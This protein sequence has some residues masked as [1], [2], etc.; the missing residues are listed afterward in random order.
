M[1]VSTFGASQADSLDSCI[2]ATKK[3][4]VKFDR[5]KAGGI[6]WLSP[7]SMGT[8]T[9]QLDTNLF[10]FLT[11]NNRSD[12]GYGQLKLLDKGKV[13]N[14]LQQNKTVGGQL[15]SIVYT[16]VIEKIFR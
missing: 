1:T 13:F 4:T 16:F 7:D 12:T 14:R 5:F 3:W 11:N 10:Y 15:Y 9:N 2:I 8:G 6:K